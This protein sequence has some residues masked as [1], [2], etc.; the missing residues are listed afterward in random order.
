M[1]RKIHSNRDPNDTLMRE[2]RKEF[3]A[4][5]SKA[6]RVSRTILERRP[7]M[8]YSVMVLLL[9]GSL[10]IS[11]VFVRH[12]DKP[13]AGPVIAKVSPMADGFSQIIRAGEKLKMTI[14]LK[15][16]VDSLSSKKNLTAKDSLALDSAL[17]RLQAIQKSIK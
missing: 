13:K 4:Y 15:R 16:F 5:F 11:F 14:S 6:G 17:D 2:I 10:V 1:F 8:T 3:S 9:T 12:S 7:R